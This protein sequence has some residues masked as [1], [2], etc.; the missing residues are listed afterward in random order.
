VS[1]YFSG[2]DPVFWLIGKY[3]G[4]WSDAATIASIHYYGGGYQLNE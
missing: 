2:K 3:V 1:G 4:R